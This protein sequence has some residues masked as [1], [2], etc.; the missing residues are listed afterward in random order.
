M[1]DG[2]LTAVKLH[3]AD[4][5]VWAGVYDFHP[6]RVASSV[7]GFLSSSF[8]ADYVK[9]PYFRLCG[10]RRNALLLLGLYA[11]RL[12]HNCGAIEVCSPRVVRWQRDL[13]DG[14]YTINALRQCIW[15]Q[16]AGGFHVFDKRD[17]FSYELVSSLDV[18]HA[19]GDKRAVSL[20]QSHVAWPILSFI[21]TL[22][23]SA[24]ALLIAL[25]LDPR[26]YI[27]VRCPSRGAALRNYLGL[28]PDVLRQVLEGKHDSGPALRCAVVLA[29][30]YAK[31]KQDL[32]QPHNF[33]Y[34]VVVHHK[35]PLKGLLRASQ[36]FIDML[37]LAWLATL[38]GAAPSPFLPE[39]FFRDQQEADAY[40]EHMRCIDET[41][42]IRYK[43]NGCACRL[44][45]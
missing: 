19:A 21:P 7:Y 32:T 8:L 24:A 12:Q 34:R 2:D 16:S 22:N 17:F 18:L 23:V 5:G 3:A 25:I 38:Q 31:E 13:S 41:S 20:L 40:V 11:W 6:F 27:D 14:F 33:L 30:W 44:V 36:K 39:Q 37:R 28:R 42:I 45:E 35:N 43:N 4:D 1:I 9:A 26:W 15:A 29:S 10:H